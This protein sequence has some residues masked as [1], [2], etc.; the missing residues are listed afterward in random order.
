MSYK[1]LHG[2]PLPGWVIDAAGGGLRMTSSPGH[3]LHQ[4]DVLG[5]NYDRMEQDM[6]CS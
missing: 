2:H 5:A 1:R 3:F 4:T 6:G